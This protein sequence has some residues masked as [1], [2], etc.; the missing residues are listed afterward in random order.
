MDWHECIRKR[1]VKDVKEDRN[2]II[3]AREIAAI[4]V[5][6]ADVLPRE[7]SVGKITLLYDAL[8]E[9][10]ECLALEKGFKIYNHECYAAFLREIGGF[11]REAEI[12]LII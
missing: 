2:L 6:S 10:L 1:I 4:K 5:K 9:Y 12:F 8:R 11:S 3:S 7:L